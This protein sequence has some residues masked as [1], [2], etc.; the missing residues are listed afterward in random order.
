MDAVTRLKNVRLFA[1]LTPDN[2]A[3]VA[4]VAERQSYPKGS[5]LCRQDEFGKTL[6]IVDSGEA[7]RRQADLSG[8]ERPVDYLRPG[9]I[10]GDDALLFGDAYSS[11]VQSTTDIKVLAISKERFDRLLDEHPEISKQLRPSPLIRDRLR[12]PTFAWLEADEQALLLRRRHWFA[13]VRSLLIPLIVWLALGFG[14]WLLIRTD[15]VRSRLPTFVLISILPAGAMVWQFLDWRNDF[16]LVTDRRVLHEEKVILLYES[17]QEARLSKIQNIDIRLDGLGALLGFGTL[18]IHTAS[19]RGT[20]TLDHLPDP[21][22]MQ[23]IIFKA[24]GRLRL[25]GRE[26]ER[27]GVRQELLRQTGRLEQEP[28]PMVVPP[29]ATPRPKDWRQMMPRMGLRRPLLRTHF[30]EAAQTV[31]RKHWIFLLGQIWLAVPAFLIMTVVTL[32]V[33]LSNWPRTYHSA[34]FLGSV[35]LWVAAFLWLWWQI[36]DWRNDLYILTDR[37]IVDVEKRPLSLS[38]QRKQARL[39]MIQSVSLEKH[40]FLSSVLDYGNVVMET[41][42][43]GGTFTFDGVRHP[44]KVQQAIFRRMEAFTEERER[45]QRD[46]RKADLA[47]W[48]RIYHQ[49]N[50]EGQASGNE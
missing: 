22:G 5:R 33:G 3:R 39:D 7:I 17:W 47:T 50:Q 12:T 13:L 36:E 43:T 38:V 21:L 4:E 31:W 34:L 23:E 35:V 8:V 28:E 44:V 45:Q 1:S 42:G 10:F 30:K 20:L 32:S 41:A 27:E 2:L 37:M 14:A 48:F 40:G 29:Y 16:Y 25:K 24:I 19:A 11:C 15:V 49:L 6:Y 18:F 46:Q 26:Q 9:D